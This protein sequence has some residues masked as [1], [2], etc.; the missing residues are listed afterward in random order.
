VSSDL[1]SDFGA[2][3]VG[4]LDGAPVEKDALDC[5]SVASLNAKRTRL[6]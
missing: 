2:L 1:L 5:D 3:G 6:A 4:D